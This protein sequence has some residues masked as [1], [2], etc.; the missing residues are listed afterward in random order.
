MAH[1]SRAVRA[2]AVHSEGIPL[3][4]ALSLGGTGR[5]SGG[6]VSHPLH[7]CMHACL[8]LGAWPFAL[9]RIAAVELVSWLDGAALPVRD[10]S[11]AL[12]ADTVA[13]RLQ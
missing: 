5:G 1:Q 11:L 9:R 4:F 7:A 10:R 8:R 13:Q 12:G 2:N 6:G 3:A